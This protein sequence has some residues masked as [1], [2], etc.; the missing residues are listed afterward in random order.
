MYLKRLV[1]R[2]FK[3]FAS[4]TSL[5]LE[6][7]ITCIVGPNG[8]GKS[9]IVDALAW[10]M[11][12]QGAK[13]L[14]GGS[15]E[16]VIFV[17][18]RTKAPLGRAEI[19]LTIDNADGALPIEYAEVTISRTK[20]RNGDS[21]YAINGTTCRLLDVREL[22]SDSG[23]G[24]EMHVVVGQGQVDQVLA[25]APEVRRGFI[26]EAAGVLKY[27]ERKEKALRKLESTRANADRLTDLV[28]EIRRQLKP[29]GRQAEVAKR[30]ATIQ[31]DLRDA[32]ARLLADDLVSARALLG[33]QAADEAGLQDRRHRIE[34]AL[35]A[36]RGE[37]DTY[38]ASGAGLEAQHRAVSGTWFSLSET[39]ERVRSLTNLA[40]ERVRHAETMPVPEPN[41]ARDPDTLLAQAQQ[42]AAEEAGLRAD[43]ERRTAELAAATA[44]R[45]AIETA[46]LEAEREY[47]ALARAQA[48]RREG[49]ARLSGQITSIRARLEQATARQA[50]LE[51]ASRAG[52][53]EA[54]AAARRFEEA[55]AGLPGLQ[56]GEADLDAAY[57]AAEAAVAAAR[58]EVE[59]ARTETARLTQAE[60]GL[61]ARVEALRLAQRT[62]GQGATWVAGESGVGGVVGPL[63]SLIRVEPGYEKAVAAGLG[64]V[65]DAVVV[66]DLRTSIA[67]LGALK[68]AAK[69]RAGLVVAGA[70][71]PVA[72]DEVWPAGVRPLSGVYTGEAR[73]VATIA[74]ITGPVVVVESAEQA[75]GL[76]AD[77]PGVRVVTRD[78]DLLSP[79]WVMGGTATDDSA[80]QI[81]AALAEAEERLAATAAD[82]RASRTALADAEARRTDAQARLTAAEQALN[83]SDAARAAAEE[84]VSLLSQAARMARFEAERRA[85]L[86][87][88]AAQDLAKDRAG[89]AEAEAR[90]AAAEASTSTAEPDPTA[91][92]DLAEQA[93]VGRAAEME[94][95]LALR[96]LEERVRA[97]GGQADGLRRAAEVERTTRATA[98]QRR[99]ELVRM[100]GTARTVAEA[101]RWLLDRTLAARAVAEAARADL[102]AARTEAAEGA[103]RAAARVRELSDDLEKLID[104]AHREELER[105]QQAMRVESLAE[106]A[107]AEVGLDQASLVSGYGPDQPV[108]TGALDEAGE[109]VTRPYVRDEQLARLRA[110]ERD[111]VILGKVNPLAGE[112]FDAMQER[113]A[114]LVRQLEDVRKTRADLLSIVDEVDARVREVFT[115][116]YADVERE[117]EATFARLFPGGEGRL[118]LT[119]PDDP[120]TTG[121]DIEARPAGKNVKR[122]SL[123]S[124]GERALVG[125]CFLIA[126]FRARP[127]PFYIL[128]EVE[129]ALDDTN[130]GRLLEIYEE[131]R[132]S[133]QLLVITHQKRTME[134]AD[135]LYGVT[136]GSDGVSTVVSQRLRED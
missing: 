12:E 60:A 122:L 130:L 57:E 117:F 90:L 36:A 100:A 44:A 93:R 7:G 40:T 6:P 85:E 63:A 31:A 71:A 51:E 123:L 101:G 125:V 104:S 70:P 15:M 95:R 42:I 92:D 105:T 80:I 124:G 131:L 136:M 86:A 54:D 118:I 8:S 111:L 45:T 126:L 102:E 27:R 135:T 96:T 133:S 37:E 10:V 50:Q 132:A 43:V 2:G 112:E 56:A 48:D 28:T 109:P 108:P 26:E 114:F 72:A 99:A 1:L 66:A 103:R 82:V 18:T 38:R 11:G 94:A 32:K 89:L 3:S 81:A 67:A 16:D 128:D 22:L 113:H 21:E 29:L 88:R 19:A 4:A 97:L 134:I 30:A 87:E 55:A 47:A 78:G 84:G 9:N 17:G 115:Q 58:A 5:T 83:E 49:L 53:A 68:A 52:G 91:K 120:L 64:D 119:D 34:A 14:R 61:T 73:V 46:Q 127:S 24:R 77:H 25:A 13:S 79:W 110:A 107:L 74:Q 98:E 41:P 75:P 35:I 65:A 106:R 116:A 129:A 59:A 62:A 33:T 76:L 23:I 20:F 121:V 39:A 69:G